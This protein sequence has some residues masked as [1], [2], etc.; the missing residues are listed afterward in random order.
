MI[1][2][3]TNS[4]TPYY[5]NEIFGFSKKIVQRFRNDFFKLKDPFRKITL[6][7]QVDTFRQSQKN[8]LDWCGFF[9]AWI[10]LDPVKPR[11][12]CQVTVWWRCFYSLNKFRSWILFKKLYYSKKNYSQVNLYRVTAF[13]NLSKSE[14]RS[15]LKTF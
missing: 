10:N 7:K 14:A 11:Q 1:F 13:Y 2:E 12:L 15:S 5:L 6:V 8:F 9:I 3:S 4:D